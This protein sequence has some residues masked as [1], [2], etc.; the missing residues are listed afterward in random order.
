MKKIDKSAMIA[1]FLA[2]MNRISEAEPGAFEE[3]AEDEFDS[4]LSQSL[5]DDLHR[6]I[7]TITLRMSSNTALAADL[8]IVDRGIYSLMESLV[9]IAQ[10][11]SE[12]DKEL[13]EMLGSYSDLMHEISNKKNS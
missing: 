3:P 8:K 6:D 1:N 2:N 9:D 4:K 7:Q 5:S 12:T 11:Y 10:T 13:E